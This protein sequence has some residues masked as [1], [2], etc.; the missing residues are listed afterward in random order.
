MS[1]AL[2]P[3]CERRRAETA[4]RPF[5]SKRCA[6]LDLARWLKGSYAIPGSPTDQADETAKRAGEDE[7]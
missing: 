2:C 3:M 7:T 6:D 5:C 4:Y 1:T